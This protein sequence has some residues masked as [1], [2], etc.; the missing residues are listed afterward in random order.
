MVAIK[1]QLDA[2]GV[3]M[4]HLTNDI[5]S[6][7]LSN[8]LNSFGGNGSTPSRE[9]CRLEG[10][11]SGVSNWVNNVDNLNDSD[12]IKLGGLGLR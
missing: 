12:S 7:K 1:G 8:L 2:E 10:L 4:D 3:R 9:I 6:L 5:K 11:I